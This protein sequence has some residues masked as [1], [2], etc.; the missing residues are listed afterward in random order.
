MARRQNIEPEII[1][2]YLNAV[3]TMADRIETYSKLMIVLKSIQLY[4]F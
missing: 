1:I 3:K 2:N 4:I